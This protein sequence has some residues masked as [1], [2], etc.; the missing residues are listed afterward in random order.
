V[1]RRPSAKDSDR[2]KGEPI[3][4]DGASPAGGGRPLLWLLLGFLLL[5]FTVVQTV[6]PVAAWAAPVFLVRYVRTSRRTGLSLLGIF[7]AYLVG[8]ILAM[9]GGPVE[10]LPVLLISLLLFHV[11]RA[12]F[13]TLPYAADRLAGNRLPEWPRLFVFPAVSTAGEWLLSLARAPNTT[14]SI[15]YSQH[16]SLALMQLLSI[17]GMWG[18]IFLIAWFASTMNLL[19]EHEFHWREVRGPMGLYAGALAVVFVFGQARL[20]LPASPSRSVEVAAVT[21]DDSVQQSAEAGIDWLA[22]GRG[23]DEQRAVAGAQL[24]PTLS[25]MLERTETALRD[26]AK[27][28]VWAEGSGTILEEDREQTLERVR[29]LAQR[30]GAYIEP[31]LAVAART[32]NQH[33][34]LNQAVLVDPS[35]E[36]LWTYEKSYPTIPVESYY[37]VAGTGELPVANTDY[38]LMSTAIC[39]DLHFPPLIRQAGSRAAG[40]FLAPFNDVPP[41]EKEDAVGATYRAIENGFSLV[42]PAD[43]GTSTIVDSRGRIL[44]SQDSRASLGGVML[45]SVPVGGARTVYAA[46]G[47]T[48]AYGCV[49]ATLLLLSQAVLGRRRTETGGAPS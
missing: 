5:P 45:A 41:F 25:Q 23:S 14:A 36:V 43:N 6:L 18:I 34:L 16:W 10:N 46:W 8:L 26:G 48:Y 24:A 44:A 19:W 9:R 21:L 11:S 30:Y 4:R 28:V 32:A 40:L 27:I 3:G 7:A 17:T 49:A 35:G 31:A 12:L 22:L 29:S 37:T 20:M 38:G 33:F 47:D 13:S 1:N 39:N 2:S 42:R 15:A